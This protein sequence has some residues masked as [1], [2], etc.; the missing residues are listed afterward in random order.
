MLGTLVSLLV[1]SSHETAQAPTT[2]RWV[3]PHPEIPYLPKPPL[4][5]ADWLVE[6]PPVN[7]HA[8]PEAR[9][10]LHMLY[11]LSCHETL[12]GQHNF[13]NEQEFS[14]NVYAIYTGK[15][16]AVYGT[17][18][19]FA[20]DGNKDSAYARHAMVAELIRQFHT[21][22]VI[23]LCWHAVP[24][25][26]DEPVTFGGQILSRLT[27]AEFD[28]LLTSGTAIHKH[29]LAQV[30]SIAEYLKELR[31][32]HVPILW[33]P[34]HEINGDWFWWNGVRGDAGHGTKQLYR[35]LY[36]RLVNFHHLDNLLWVWNPDRPMRA[37]R[38]YVDYFPGLQ[39]VDV[40]GLDCYGAFEQ[41]FYDEL[42]ALS[43]G[44][45]MAISE[46]YN[47][48]LIDIY[49]TEPKWAYYMIWAI[50]KPAAP[51]FLA[52]KRPNGLTRDRFRAI[53]ADPRM[54]S[55]QD[56]GYRDAVAPVLRAAGDR[57]PRRP[58]PVPEKPPFD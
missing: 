48:P 17:D 54:L 30:D 26:M 15:T 51:A 52:G 25:T 23:A 3:E 5:A 13:I 42:N 49:R 36:D 34:Y 2:R 31:D 9:A 35:Q 4:H 58:E 22:H 14:T 1:L 24:P 46:T 11:R 8:S 44:K 19:G 43:G 28:A 38:Q 56:R 16:P 55:L 10:L 7:P 57:L 50:D 40:L 37:D 45:V 6:Q 39:Y 47:P 32:A 27:D 29:W 41:R 33:R 12:T 18:L 20:A 21:G 53:V